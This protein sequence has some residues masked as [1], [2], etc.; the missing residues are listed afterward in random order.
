MILCH[1]RTNRVAATCLLFTVALLMVPRA[2]VPETRFD[3]ANTPTN[4]MVVEKVAA[5][6][7]CQKS[8][9]P[10]PPRIFVV[11][12]RISLHSIVLVH[13]DR[14]T[15]SRPVQELLSTLLC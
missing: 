11:K 6:Q 12:R 1:A 15:G 4:E 10:L 9:A 13:P 14:L 3:E 7:E 8:I 5:S 2:D